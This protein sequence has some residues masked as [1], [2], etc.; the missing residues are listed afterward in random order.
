VSEKDWKRAQAGEE[1]SDEYTQ[2]ECRD[3]EMQSGKYILACKRYTAIKS[4][5]QH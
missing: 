3:R 4:C 1:T 2:I 5:T